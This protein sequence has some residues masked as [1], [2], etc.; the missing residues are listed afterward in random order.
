MGGIDA[1]QIAGLLIEHQSAVLGY[2]LACVRNHSD[3]EDI[4]QEVSVAAVQLSEQLE[5][6]DGFLPWVRQIARFRILKH[7]E[8]SKRLV[9]TN[10]ELIDQL[11][12]VAEEMDQEGLRTARSRHLNNCIDSLPPESRRMILMRY[13]DRKHSVEEIA[14]TA[15][16]SVQA[17]YA[18]LKR[19]RAALRDC[20]S[21]KL[22][23]AG[24]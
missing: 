21:G 16:R 24:A 23:E 18:L 7:I 13:S 12:L 8:Q 3:A 20:V 17:T 4:Y 14:Q 10:V 5:N 2:I 11:A 19:I 15:N 6:R 9:P 22:A 1:S